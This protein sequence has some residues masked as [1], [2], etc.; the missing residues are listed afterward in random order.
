MTRRSL[1]NLF[2]IVTLA[3]PVFAQMG[4]DAGRRSGVR[5]YN[6]ATELTV[7][8]T[9][10]EV[11]KAEGKRGWAGTH[12]VLKADQ[13]TFDVHLGPTSYIDSQEFSFG[14]GDAIEVIGSKANIGGK[15]V[16]IA[17][18]VTKDGRVLTLRNERGRPLWSG[19]S[20]A[21]K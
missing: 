9:I 7:K 3:I 21:Q 13:G 16:L 8:G 1:L 17:R 20:A 4:T 19:A 18:Q 6:P 5:N 12:L 15:D 2:L 10:E 14:K 11:R